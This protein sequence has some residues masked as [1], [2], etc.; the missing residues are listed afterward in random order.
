MTE[1]EAAIE[2][3]NPPPA[4]S[5]HDQFPPSEL[6]LFTPKLFGDCEIAL[7]TALTA[8]QRGGIRVPESGRLRR[9][10]AALRLAA[11]GS[12]PRERQAQVLLANAATDAIDFMEI[13][14]ALGSQ[15]AVVAADVQRAMRGGAI[16]RSTRQVAERFQSQLWL[17]SILARGGY[18]PQIPEGLGLTPDYTIEDGLSTYGVEIK[19]PD[20]ESS[21]ENRLAKGAR[22]L[23]DFGVTGCV[24]LDLSQVS[25][26]YEVAWLERSEAERTRTV[27]HARFEELDKFVRATVLDDARGIINPKFRGIST[28]MTFARSAIWIE[29]APSGV[30]I[31]ATAGGHAFL[32]PIK[33]SGYHHAIKMLERLVDGLNVAGYGFEPFRSVARMGGAFPRNW[34]L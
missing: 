5:P 21:I 13:V 14:R 18:E 26:L 11:T 12:L 33:N 15:L 25:G 28:I 7:S 19:R 1:P 9:E 20:S 10:L 30:T 31:L 8:L 22:Q 17:G 6:K 34:R 29:G 32:R 3:H 2:R 16:G 4:H 23:R 27:L 24:I